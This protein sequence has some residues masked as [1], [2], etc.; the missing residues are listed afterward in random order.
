MGNNNDARL[1]FA[2][3]VGGVVKMEKRLHCRKRCFVSG[4][5]AVMEVKVSIYL[6]HY[7]TM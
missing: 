6:S 3:V 2:T 4:V 1:L 5:N 7:K